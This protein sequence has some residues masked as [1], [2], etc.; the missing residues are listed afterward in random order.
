MEKVQ[1]VERWIWMGIFFST[2]WVFDRLFGDTDTIPTR[3]GCCVAL[4]S[5]LVI[6]FSSGHPKGEGSE[7]S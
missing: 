2:P 6:V 3:L 5:I 4:A 7:E 1:R